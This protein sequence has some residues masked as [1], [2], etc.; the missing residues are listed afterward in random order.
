MSDACKSVG[1]SRLLMSCEPN[2]IRISFA[3]YKIKS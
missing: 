3:R 2:L 1:I